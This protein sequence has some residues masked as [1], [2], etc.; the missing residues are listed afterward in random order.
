MN[1]GNFKLPVL[2]IKSQLCQQLLNYSV[3]TP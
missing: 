3:K 1:A 2:C